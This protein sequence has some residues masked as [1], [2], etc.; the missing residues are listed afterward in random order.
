MLKEVCEGLEKDLQVQ[1]FHHV[2]DYSGV[3][4]IAYGFGVSI[5]ALVN[6]KCHLLVIHLQQFPLKIFEQVPVVFRKLFN[7]RFGTCTMLIDEQ[8]LI[9]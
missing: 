7:F 3:D 4:L 6:I 2:L 9:A 1:D 8:V 5:F